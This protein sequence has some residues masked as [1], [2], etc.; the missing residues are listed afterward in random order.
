MTSK[1]VS[2][3][4][5]RG[6]FVGQTL[7]DESP[8]EPG[9]FLIPRLAVDAPPPEVPE[10]HLAGWNG[11]NWFFEKAPPATDGAES[12]PPAEET[13][14]VPSVVTR[15]Q[16]KAALI[17]SGYWQAVL[18]YVAAIDDPVQRALTEVALND[19]QTWQRSSPFLTSVAQALGLSGE[20]LDDLFL[21]AASI[22]L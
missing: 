12:E 7:A 3:C 15:A 21:I 20:Q 16:G 22:E 8:L 19:T 5:E 2:Q 10:G 17:Q 6:Y 9:V 4:D 13:P 11:T 14:S 18:D 1:V